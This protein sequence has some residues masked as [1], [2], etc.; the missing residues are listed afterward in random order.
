M[1]RPKS[2]KND[3]IPVSEQYWFVVK[4][5]KIVRYPREKINKWDREKIFLK[6]NGKCVD[7]GD[8]CNGGWRYYKPSVF[9]FDL[10]GTHEIH[11]V[12]S[13][14]KGGGNNFNNLILLCI[15]CHQKR[16]KLEK[17]INNGKA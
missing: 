3:F 4:K 10:N 17:E 12:I 5:K 16:H 11:H 15:P 13:I 2:N 8:I 7:C 1:A 14:K 6:S 9:H